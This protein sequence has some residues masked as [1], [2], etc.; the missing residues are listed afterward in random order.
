MKAGVVSCLLLFSDAG[1]SRWLIPRAP[2]VVLLF[3]LLAAPLCPAP[4]CSGATIHV[5]TNSPSNGPGTAWSNAFWTIQGGVDAATNA[6]DVVLV[7]NGVY[8]TGTRVAPTYALMNRVCVTNAITVRSVNG[9]SN[10]VIVGRGPVGNSAVRCIYLANGALLSGF[11]LTN[12]HTRTS[13]NADDQAGGGVFASGASV[14]NCVIA[15]NTADERGGG[16]YGGA[17]DNCTVNG[18]S[19][20]QWGGGLW[21]ATVNRCTIT[22]N[23]ATY[24]GGLYSCTTSRSTISD[25]Y[26]SAS[27]GGAGGG[28]LSDCT[29]SGNVAGTSGGG[30]SSATL[31][32]C[33]VSGNSAL[34]GNGGGSSGGSLTRCTVRD[35]WASDKG[36][37]VYNANP[38]NCLITGNVVAKQ[39][40]GVYGDARNCAIVGN[41][42][43]DVGGGSYGGDIRN[44]TIT[45]NQAIYGGGVQG[46]D[47]DNCIVYDNTAPSGPNYR[48]SAF[49]YSCTTP[50]PGGTGNIT[51]NPML[52]SISHI[53]SNSPCAG[54]GHSS[55]AAG[56]DIDGEAWLN[57]PSMG[58]DE[59]AA[60][61]VTGTLT[62]AIHADFTNA[63]VGAAADFRADIEGAATRNIW[64]FGD[65]GAATNRAYV[66]H[67][68]SATGAFPVVLTAYSDTVPGGAAD[69]VTVY[70]VT[71]AICYV[72]INNT[73]PVSPY[74]SWSGA[75][76]NIQDAIDACAAAGGTV[77]V[78]NGVYGTGGRVTPGASLTNRIAVTKPILVES[79]NGP[80][81][82]MIVGQG[83]AGDS[84]VRCAYL[85]DGAVLSGFT[86]TNGHARTSG[87]PRTD[88]CGGG[89]YALGALV[90]NCLITGNNAGSGD[91][92]RGG[93]AYAGTLNNCTLRGNTAKYG[94]GMSQSHLNSCTNAGNFASRSGGGAHGGYLNGC[95]LT[96]NTV[97]YSGGGAYGGTLTNCTIISNRATHST[98]ASGAGVR[99]VTAYNCLFTN[100]ISSES[101]GAA[102]NSTL[103]D[104]TLTGNR[105]DYGGGVSGGMLNNCVIMGNRAG[106]DGGGARSAMLNSCT[107]SD[108]SASRDGGG[109]DGGT[110]NYCTLLDNSASRYGGGMRDSTLNNCVLSG[111]SATEQG[112]G[113]FNGSVDNCTITGN[114]ALYAGGTSGGT[115]R[116]CIVFYNSA[117]SGANYKDGTYLYTCTTPDPGGTGNITD[118]PLLVSLS[119]IA[120]NSP[121][122]GRGNDAYVAGTDIDGEAWLDPPSMGCDEYAGAAVTGD[123]TVA[124]DATYTNVAVGFEAD[125]RANVDGAASRTSWG[126]GDG[127]GA[128]NHPYM[129]HAWSAAGDYAVVLTAYN[130]TCPGGVADTVTVHVVAESIHYVDVGNTTPNSPYTS[131]ADAATNIQDAVDVCNVGGGKVLVTNGSYSVGMRTVDGAS[132]PN[133]IVVTKAI[134][135][136]SVGGPVFTSIGGNGPNGDAAVRCAYLSDGAVL[137]GF[138]LTNGHTRT[139]GDDRRDE[140]GGGVYAPDGFLTNCVISH[141]SAYRY[142]GGA[143]FGTL[144]DCTVSTNSAPNNAAG[145]GGAYEARLEGCTLSGNA[146][147]GDGGGANGGT[148][149]HCA[150]NGNSTSDHGGGA[151]GATLNDCEVRANRA[152]GQYSRGGGVRD[153]TLNRCLVEGNYANYE[154]GGVCGGTANN[155]L[156]VTNSSGSSAGGMFESTLN[157]CTVSGN[158]ATNY[159]GGTY[160]GTINNSV[161]YFNTAPSSSNYG[162]GVWSHS[163]TTPD[164][165]GTNNITG[166]PLFLDAAAGDYHLAPTS[167]CVN[168]GDNADAPGT[169]DLDGKPRIAE[170]TVDMGAHEVIRADLAVFKSDFPDPVI[171]GTMLTYTILVT[172][173]GPSVAEG[174]VVTDSLPATVVFDAA[175]SPG[176]SE[177]GGI[178]I[179][180]VGTL[181]AGASTSLTLCV[182][183]P[184]SLTNDVANT[185]VVFSPTLDPVPANNSAAEST[186]VITRAD[187]AVL[188]SDSPD[189]VVAGRAL[190]YV[191]TVTNLGP[192]DAL[193][194]AVTDTLPPGVSPGGVVT[195]N[196]GTL[197]AGAGTSFAINVGVDA[198]TLGTI[199]NTAEVTSSTTDTNSSND[200]VAEQTTVNDESDLGLTKDAS[201]D[202]VVAGTPLTYTLYVTNAGPSDARN[203]QVV[204]ILPPGV[205]P[206]G[207]DATDLGTLASHSSTSF[208]I[209]VTVNSSTLGILTNNAQVTTSATDTNPANDGA[210]EFSTVIARADLGVA[211]S[212]SANPVAGMPV[213]YTVTVTN[214]GPS[215]AQAVQVTDTLPPSVTPSDPVVTNLGT[216]AAG[217]TASFAIEVTVNPDAREAVT[218][219]AEVTSSTADTNAANDTVSLATIAATRADLGVE[220]TD[221][222]DPVVS[223]NVITYTIAVTNPGPSYAW[224]VVVTDSL[225][226]GVTIDLGGSPGWVATNSSYVYDVGMLA[227]GA[228]T[229]LTLRVTVGDTTAGSVTNIVSVGTTSEDTN[230]VDSV[231]TEGT[232]VRDLD[233]DG[234]PDF[235]DEDDDNDSMPDSWE[236]DHGLDPTN[237]ADAAWN[238][239]GDPHDNA[240]EWIADTDPTDS[241]DYFRITDVTVA[242]PPV[243]SFESSSNRWYSLL[244]RFSLITGRWSLV[245][246]EKGGG[247]ADSLQDTNV[248]AR[249]PLYRLKVTLP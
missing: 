220:K 99:D 163:C 192:S 208:A 97:P 104:C 230:L 106:L 129:S 107:L 156:I 11:T 67:A 20:P 212:D 221:W 213:T 126:F 63:V 105:G 171:A 47:L 75:A 35:N 108:N 116:N 148:L 95:T 172:N 189:P 133:R 167:L 37:G 8:D 10:T 22:G 225:P 118:A 164:P 138:T 180:A 78:S 247:G 209:Q 186:E 191:V 231:D 244:G 246:G 155:C 68:W 1:R 134:V 16:G 211:K 5:S 101:G 119:H 150:L 226:A 44:C 234:D 98:S 132:L 96:A 206:T 77:L 113:T 223:S 117:V 54:A 43:E 166:D 32:D 17:Y 214:A 179:Y 190:S 175:G 139:S 34:S 228:G 238:L 24:A 218:N 40:G 13:G 151:F 51:N 160:G 184:S 157:N 159:H 12:G 248:P 165:G 123:L 205:T 233:N 15:G 127:N 158:A 121:C 243:I 64:T 120:S 86:L 153:C 140:S 188:K 187:L 72:D 38:R 92:N 30:S 9:P 73:R 207:A 152:A 29:I 224:D 200:S 137:S 4:L 62:V 55:Y 128:T 83:P 14:S 74:A 81:A 242:S 42:S 2:S 183:V 249:G 59:V 130:D 115:I 87:K 100:N 195:T 122:I 236:V 109:A 85:S 114:E 31:T 57:P 245:T 145:G 41:R 162:G 168:A 217:T 46:G 110:L 222:P 93:G 147:A 33:T 70:V 48:D 204:D 18:N 135:V 210:S 49:R 61:A 199:G 3:S 36:G 66:S 19:G 229:S 60:G 161:V 45:G 176:W 185:V 141:N 169:T 203:V 202:T 90:T 65:G 240:S 219:V 198:S 131:W 154:G 144:R 71:Q 227:D 25:N 215:D 76:T 173:L 112:G 174:A 111:N 197:V 91:D 102:Y 193:S 239:D 232:T 170:G 136:Q 149:S 125:F 201:L 21:G 235:H 146:T 142:G 28:S 82:T 196:L 26:S 50:D 89:V 23:S 27:G 69:T 39:G 241:N 80:E 7:T 88:Q 84:A 52:V 6:G 103:N 124:I 237:A 58:C 143:C 56:T 53:A 182:S 178:A 94:G 79:V 181:D 216:L 194:V 177:A